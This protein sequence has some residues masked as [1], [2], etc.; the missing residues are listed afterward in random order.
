[1]KGYSRTFRGIV[2]VGLSLTMLLG[3]F[4]GTVFSAAADDVSAHK[5]TSRYPLYQIVSETEKKA[6]YYKYYLEDGDAAGWKDVAAGSKVSVDLTAGK[7]TAYV[8]ADKEAAEGGDPLVLESDGS[9]RWLATDV[10]EASWTFSVTKSGYYCIEFEYTALPG[11]VSPPRRAITIDGKTPYSEISN[12]HFF[13][14]W[15]DGGP[16]WINAVG[17]EVR[18]KQVEENVRQTMLAVDAL[19]RYNE[20]LKVY[21]T[22]GE[23]T[24]GMNALQE[25]ILLHAI[26]FVTPQ[27]IAPYQEVLE[28]YKAKGYQN[29]TKEIKIDAEEADRKSAVSLR[30]E[31][32]S[33]PLAD[34]VSLENIVL[35][36]IGGASWNEGNQRITWTF[37]VEEAGLYKINL[38]AYQKYNDGLA[39]YRQIRIDGEVP[40]REFLCYAFEDMEWTTMTLKNEE[41]DEPYLVYLTA[42]SHTIDM[43][44]KN[45]PYNDILLELETSVNTLSLI[46]QNIIRIT[47]IQPDT[48]FDYQLEKKIPWLLDA[49]QEIVDSLTTQIDLLSEMSGKKSSTVSSLEEVRYRLKELIKDPFD[50]PKYLQTMIDYQTTLAA[51]INNFNNLAVMLDYMTLTPPD[52]KVPNKHANVFQYIWYGIKQFFISFTKDYNAV[53]GNEE[54]EKKDA[55]LLVW[56]AQGREWAETLKQICDEDFIRNRDIGVTFNILPSGALGGSFATVTLASAVLLL[57]A[58]SVSVS[59]RSY[60]PSGN[61]ASGPFAVET[62]AR[63]FH[64]YVLVSPP[65]RVSQAPLDRVIHVPLPAGS[66]APV[67]AFAMSGRYSIL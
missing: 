18:P 4:S 52:Q 60:S 44:V 39:S 24:I 26:S 64:S 59:L 28:G 21:L 48:G 50:I 58:A 67:A 17:D 43:A 29:A 13:R 57:P 34:P 31:V 11:S 5:L 33:D 25:D 35:N 2:A 65:L 27:V 23:H 56:V 46:V 3:C 19:G 53:N 41:T 30:R 7:A 51:Y 45:A 10:S 15:K 62:T 32:S 1:M 8:T 9:F 12:I 55:N 6:P 63:V 16:T 20:P 22:A 54:G 42:G 38:R 47:G 36:A 49:F 66:M 61:L 37:D 40:F 14:L